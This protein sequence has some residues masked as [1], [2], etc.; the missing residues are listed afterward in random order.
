MKTGEALL[1]ENRII[2]FLMSELN[3][4]AD[5]AAEE[6]KNWANLV[7]QERVSR[8]LREIYTGMLEAAGKCTEAESKNYINQQIK[9]YQ[10]MNTN[11]IK[12]GNKYAVAVGRNEVEMEVTEKTERGWKVKTPAGKTLAINNPDRFIRCLS[13]PEPQAAIETPASSGRKMSMLGAAVEIL[14]TADNPMNSKQ[15]IA[16][17]EGANLWK[18]PGGKT[19]DRTLAAAIFREIAHKEN[20]R[21]VKTAPGLFALNREGKEG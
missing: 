2:H 6:W 8:I 19:P 17:M 12:V 14:K 18:S 5:E 9:E 13:Q 7:D 10:E 3:D 21:F 15:L 1:E 20:P 11:E 16:A 4:A